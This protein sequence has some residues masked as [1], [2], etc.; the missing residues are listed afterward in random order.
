MGEIMSAHALVVGSMVPILAVDKSTNNS[1]SVVS[2]HH[3][4]EKYSLK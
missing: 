2:C 1:L 4:H 3:F